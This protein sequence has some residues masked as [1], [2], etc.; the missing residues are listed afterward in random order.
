MQ[1]RKNKLQRMRRRRAREGKK[2]KPIVRQDARL[3]KEYNHSES[4]D[5]TKLMRIQELEVQ[6]E[7]Y[8]Q[9]MQTLHSNIT[10]QEKARPVQEPASEANTESPWDHG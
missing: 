6:G 3:R 2:C 5:E 8:R 1:E 7:K 9:D 10:A 4:V